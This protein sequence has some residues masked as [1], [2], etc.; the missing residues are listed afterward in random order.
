MHVSTYNLT[1]LV[2]NSFLRGLY[3]VF[4]LPTSALLF[5]LYLLRSESI[6]ASGKETVGYVALG[7]MGFYMIFFVVLMIMFFRPQNKTTINWDKE[8]KGGKY[9]D[10]AKSTNTNANN[11]L[12][13]DPVTLK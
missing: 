12:T 3:F 11:V 13:I 10:Q 4:L 1:S 2:V 9:N 6:S 5:C 8:N 7:V